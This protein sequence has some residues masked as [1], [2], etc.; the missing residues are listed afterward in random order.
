MPG[1]GIYRLRLYKTSYTNLTLK[2]C[3]PLIINSQTVHIINMYITR[4]YQFNYNSFSMYNPSHHKT[5]TIIKVCT[6]YE[7]VRPKPGGTSENRYF[8]PNYSFT[9]YTDRVSLSGFTP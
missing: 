2:L 1:S 3:F 6:R 8:N 4:L 7:E 5:V 9:M